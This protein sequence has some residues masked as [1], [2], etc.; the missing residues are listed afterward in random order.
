MLICILGFLVG[1]LF[2]TRGGLYWLDIVDRAVSFYGLL[3]TGAIAAIVVGWVFPARKLREHLNETSDI[4]IGAWWDWMLKIVVPVGALFVVVYGG[5][6]KDLKEP[7]GGYPKWAAWFIWII[8]IAT[9]ILSF[10]FQA[11][12]TR[13]AKK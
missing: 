4:K 13:E 11:L 9:F 6:L 8:L 1:L 10:I 5:F 3:I 12:K 2:T 7:Y